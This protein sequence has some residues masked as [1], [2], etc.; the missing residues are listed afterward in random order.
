MANCS[1]AKENYLLTV[2]SISFVLGMAIAIGVYLGWK[3]GVIAPGLHGAVSALALLLC[4]PFILS[5]AVGPSPDSGLALTLIVGTL[6]FANGFLY[7]GV[8]SGGYFVV[9][10]MGKSRAR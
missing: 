6:V 2:L 4:P 5:F 7:A 10:L 8:A 1:A 9:T 3:S